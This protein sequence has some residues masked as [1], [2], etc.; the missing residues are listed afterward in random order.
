MPAWPGDELQRNL[1]FVHVLEFVPDLGA[2]N[3]QDHRQRHHVQRIRVHAV[4]GEVLM[5]RNRCHHR[6]QPQQQPEHAKVHGAK[7]QI[8]IH[9]PRFY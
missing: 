9:K 2:D 8:G 7:I 3:S 6:R 4:A 1:Q 5:Q